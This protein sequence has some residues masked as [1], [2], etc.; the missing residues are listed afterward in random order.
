[1]VDEFIK[2]VIDTYR[3]IGQVKVM[4][5][6]VHEYLGMKLNYEVEGQV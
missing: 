1:M 4:R 2:W 3:S 5:G 6:K